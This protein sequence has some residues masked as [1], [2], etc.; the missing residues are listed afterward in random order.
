MTVSSPAVPT[1]T[2]TPA[3]GKPTVCSAEQYTREQAAAELTAEA[4]GVYRRI[5]AELLKLQKAGGPTTTTELTTT[6]G[7]AYLAG[8][9]ANLSSMV[10]Q[11][12]KLVGDVK[13]TKLT[14]VAGAGA[15]GYEA[16]LLACVDASASKVMQGK[17][18]L[19][20]GQLIAE[21]IYFKHDGDQ[22]KAWDA[23]KADLKGC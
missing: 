6:S 21:V 20:K 11:Q 13:L 8:Q 16:A 23:E 12:S 7:G 15:H 18:Q 17:T 22:L 3:I 10:Q 19:A 5:F 4:V 1:Y 2:C 9:Q 14:G